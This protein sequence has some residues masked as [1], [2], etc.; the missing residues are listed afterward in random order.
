MGRNDSPLEIS[1][2][3]P[4]LITRVCHFEFKSEPLLAVACSCLGFPESTAFTHERRRNKVQRVCLIPVA[5][6]VVGRKAC[7][8]IENITADKGKEGNAILGEEQASI[9]N[10]SHN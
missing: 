7:R 10:G 4:T 3:K 9:Q 1:L 2:F 5:G 6:Q 8:G